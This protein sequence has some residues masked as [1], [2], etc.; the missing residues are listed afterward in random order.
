LIKGSKDFI[1]V[2]PKQQ[3]LGKNCPKSF[4]YPN[5]GYFTLAFESE[6]LES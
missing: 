6:S 3:N 5:F 4:I 1:K 2:W